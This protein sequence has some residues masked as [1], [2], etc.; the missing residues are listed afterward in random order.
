[1]S[2][3]QVTLV[4][5]MIK[6][7]GAASR[8]LASSPLNSYLLPHPPWLILYPFIPYPATSNQLTYKNPTLAEQPPLP[9]PIRGPT[10]LFCKKQH[11]RHEIH[12]ID[13]NLLSLHRTPQAPAEYIPKR[14]AKGKV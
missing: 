2:C 14:G 7:M 6:I 9:L 10:S 3:S 12:P 11:L 1:M 4:I 5:L 8:L 13:R